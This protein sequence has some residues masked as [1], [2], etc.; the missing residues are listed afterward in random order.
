MHPGDRARR[1]GILACSSPAIPANFGAGR[2]AAA[3]QSPGAAAGLPADRGDRPRRSGDRDPPPHRSLRH[4]TMTAKSRWRCAGRAA[5]YERLAGF[6]EGI[7][8]GLAD[9]MRGNQA[10][11]I[12]LDGD[13]AQT[14]GAHPARRAWGRE[15]HF[16]D[17]RRRTDG[18][19]TISTSAGSGCRQIPCRSRSNRW[20]SAR[21]RAVRGRASGSITMSMARTI[22]TTTPMAGITIVTRASIPDAI[23]AGV[24]YQLSARLLRQFSN[25]LNAERAEGRKAGFD[26]A[27]ST[28]GSD[29][30]GGMLFSC[31]IPFRSWSLHLHDLIHIH[32]VVVQ[33]RHDP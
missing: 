29:R 26:Q 25:R 33:M 21:T 5:A 22:G 12:M 30:F 18:T 4:A 32:H 31:S 6:A 9:R 20:S 27:R 14:L 13:V 8:R 7:R 2:A 28:P 24:E 10:L 3:A 16:G 23:F 1:I 17:R 19:S 15:R 11:Y